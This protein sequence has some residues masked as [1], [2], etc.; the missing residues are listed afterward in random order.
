[1]S[2]EKKGI[3][4]YVVTFLAGAVIGAGMALLFAPQSGK[5]TRK[6]IK[7]GCNKIGDDI[8]EHYEKFSK[9]AQH[10][11]DVVKNTSEKAVSQIKNFVGGMKEKDA[12]QEATD[13]SRAGKKKAGA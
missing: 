3:G 4:S 2:N 6:Q 10:A 1:M 5:E 7:N 9:E 11:I 12:D 13:E 8:K